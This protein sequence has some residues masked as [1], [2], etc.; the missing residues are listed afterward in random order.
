MN[1]ILIFFFQI[2]GLC[3]IRKALDFFF[4]QADLYW[5]DHLLPDATLRSK[6]DDGLDPEEAKGLVTDQSKVGV[7]C[8]RARVGDLRN[9]GYQN[10]NPFNSNK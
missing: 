10:P 5:L 6:E 7:G 3:F 8:G 2:L 4:T 9:L 1:Q